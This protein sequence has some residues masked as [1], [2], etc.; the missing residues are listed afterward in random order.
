MPLKDFIASLS[1][2]PYFGAGAGLFGVG[3]AL[4]VA[5]KGSQVGMILFRRH[6]MMTLEVTGRDKSYQ[7]LLHWI[8]A[9]GTRTQH[10]SVE[11]TF[12]QNETGK[13]TT[14]FDFVPSTGAHFFF[15][16]GNWIRVERTREKQMVDMHIGAPWESVTLTAFGRNRQ[17]FFN[18][19][20]E[21]RQ[22]ALQKQE[23]KTVMYTAMGAEW[24]QFG[25]PRNKRPLSSVILDVG[26][27]E[28]IV[29]DVKD[30]IG[31][32]GWYRDRG[33]PYRRGYLLYG[34]PGCGKSSFIT[35]LAG[36][37]ER[38]W[39]THYGLV[40]VNIGSRNGWHQAITWTSVDLPPVRS[41]DIYLMKIPQEV[42]LS[43]FTEIS[44]TITYL[45]F[46]Q[47]SQGTMS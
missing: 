41:R 45:N 22:L 40:W 6:C 9:R 42:P 27:S 16:K 19:L 23:G 8:S 17:L 37:V 1:D 11:T 4:T 44:L 46:I 28:R 12:N 15:Y 5:R 20:D 34:P 31:N 21:A 3:A 24:R 18:L 33:I 25:Y 7:W 29:S 47:I 2:N 39:L 32:P 14:N 30:F 36:K 26:I 38:V 35:A 13:I 10:L 43:S